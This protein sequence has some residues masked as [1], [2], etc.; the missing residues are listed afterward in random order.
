MGRG[1]FRA[2]GTEYGQTLPLGAGYD[3]ES[4]T[5]TAEVVRRRD[6]PVRPELRTHPAGTPRARK[7]PGV[8]DVQLL[9]PVAPD[10]DTPYQPGELFDADVKN[11]FGRF[12][13]LRYL[14]ANFN[15]EKEWADRKLPGAMKAAW[16]DRAAVWENEVMLANETGKDLY[17]TIPVK[18]TDDYIRNLANLIRYGSDGVNPYTEPVADPVYPGLNPNL[19]VYVEWG[20]EIWNWAFSQGGLGGRR[21]SGRRP[22][23]HP[24][25]A[26]RQLRRPAPRAA[27]SA[28]GPPSGPWRRAT[29]FR[30]VW[31]DP[32][33]G[34]RVRVVLEY[35]YDNVQERRPSRPCEFLDQYLQQ[36]RRGHTSRTRTR[37][38]T[39]SRARAG[40]R[41]FGATNPRG[42]VEDIR[43][44]PAGSRDRVG[45]PGAAGRPGRHPVGVRGRRRRVPRL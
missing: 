3:P 24:R 34:D 45:P 9:R 37:S 27:T 21:R 39:T 1:R 28:G 14:T 19:R 8:A 4:N 40:P 12:T 11:A 2:D 29:I 30:E 20:N 23:R 31:G 32:A 18:A 16:G 25:G 36:R 13:T 43:V 17:I 33:M 41:Y 35:Q 38:A 6:R 15:A 5:T 22:G 42:L 10:A 7:E 26:D 44:P